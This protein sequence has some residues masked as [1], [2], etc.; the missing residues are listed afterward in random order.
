MNSNQ[1]I[2]VNG[3]FLTQRPTGVQRFALDLVLA[4]QDSFELE[5]LIPKTDRIIPEEL[6][7]KV[8]TVEGGSGH[9]WE[10]LTLP[11]YLKQND[12]LLLNLCNTAPFLWK[13]N[14]VTIHDLAFE[15]KDWVNW[16]FSLLYKFLIPRIAKSAKHVFTVSNTIKTE[17]LN[18]YKLDDNLVSVL[19]NRVS[20]EFLNA[21][22][23]EV[24]GLKDP[25]YLTVG[26][27]NPRKNYQWLS[28]VFANNEL[29]RLVIVGGEA[30]QFKA[31]NVNLKNCK[32]LGYTS[33]EELKW[34]YANA[35]GYVN[36]S[37]YE[38]F[39]IPTIEA[40]AMGLPIVC[41][42][43]PVNREVAGEEVLYAALNNEK[44]LIKQLKRVSSELINYNNIQK[45]QTFDARKV[46]EKVICEL[47]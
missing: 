42:D 8:T 22:I 14:L 19:Y 37:L 10:Q 30:Q 29:P 39:G 47:R 16:K 12:G 41:S 28:E 24:Q 11:Q 34:L 27:L 15:N 7:S 6:N 36:F 45:F 26:S 38:G 13:K 43:I 2:Y 33:I 31:A 18:R 4:I 20:D 5:I 23:Q 25:F 17:L 40:M 1:K 35:E 32:V 44:E 46:F 9:Y 3:R 21:G